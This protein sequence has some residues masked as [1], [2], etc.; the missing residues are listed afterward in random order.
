MKQLRTIIVA[1]LIL[2]SVSTFAQKTNFSGNWTIDTIRTVFGQAPKTV[3][4]KTIKIDQQ[5][6]ILTLTRISINAQFQEQAPVTEALSL[7]GTPLQRT[8][9]GGQVITTLR[10]LNDTSLALTRNG[11]N[12]NATETWSLEDGGKTL[13]IKRAVEQKENGFKYVLKCIYNKQ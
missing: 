13:V 1:F 5:A 12:F 11:V 4:P 3:I 10:W 2:N 8:V 7:A 9:D 6:D